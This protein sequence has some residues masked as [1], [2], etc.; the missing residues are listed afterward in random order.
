MELEKLLERLW[1]ERKRLTRSQATPLFTTTNAIGSFAGNAEQNLQV[2]NLDPGEYTVQF[3]PELP[4][5]GNGFSA[6][7][8]I[9]WKVAGQMQP[10][11]ISI[12][13][14][15]SISGVCDAV[16]IRIL[17]QSGDNAGA[18]RSNNGYKIIATLSKGTRPTIMQPPV[19][20]TARTQTV[21][22]AGSVHDFSVPQNAGVISVLITAV[23]G[24]GAH[25]DDEDWFAIARDPSATLLGEWYPAKTGAAFLP[26]PPGTS[27]V[28]VVNNNS[29]GQS[30]DVTLQWGIEG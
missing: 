5:D 28:R 4:G 18:P 9:N 17:D 1:H 23:T 19:L 20:V 3:N 27:T 13:Q 30:I 12:F 7:A 22:A 6:Y 11:I 29:G 8:F 24:S 26:L 15:A 16:D 21:A 2:T 25:I 10:R 14:G